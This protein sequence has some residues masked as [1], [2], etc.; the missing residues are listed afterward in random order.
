[1]V[2]AAVA[3]SAV[4]DCMR[5]E[6]LSDPH[7][8]MPVHKSDGKKWHKSCCELTA[9]SDYG[10]KGGKESL[11][12]TDCFRELRVRREGIIADATPDL[13]ETRQ[14]IHENG[15]LMQWNGRETERVESE[16]L[17]CDLMRR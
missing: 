14:N 3:L 2:S 5:E 7:F 1:M 4:A 10:R 17:V 16:V 15:E 12:S 11:L 13:R 8:R 9:V 6:R